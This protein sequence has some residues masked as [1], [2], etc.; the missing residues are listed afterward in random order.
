MRWQNTAEQWW[1]LEASCSR[2]VSPGLRPVCG[3]LHL[4]RSTLS[5]IDHSAAFGKVRRSFRLLELLHHTLLRPASYNKV[6]VLDGKCRAAQ[7]KLAAATVSLHH[8]MHL[9][10]NVWADTRASS[11]FWLSTADGFTWTVHRWGEARDWRRDMRRNR[12]KITF[13]CFCLHCT[14]Y[15]FVR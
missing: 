8:W 3:Y 6:P 13:K 7:T 9:M 15:I 10:S 4:Q 12:G 1:L 11:H 5:A 14:F 2:G